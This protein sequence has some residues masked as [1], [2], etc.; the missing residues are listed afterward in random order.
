M[1]DLVYIMTLGLCAIPPS[2]SSLPPLHSITTHANHGQSSSPPSPSADHRWFSLR[3]GEPPL[4]LFSLRSIINGWQTTQGNQAVEETTRGGG[5]TPQQEKGDKG[6]D[7]RQFGGR[8][9]NE[10]WGQRTQYKMIGQWQWWVG[11]TQ[12]GGNATI[13][14]RLGQR[15]LEQWARQ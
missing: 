11:V 4:T 10:R 5:R 15:W 3:F 13:K 9:H 12:R 14:L 7:V 2:H 6:H 8:Q 1:Y